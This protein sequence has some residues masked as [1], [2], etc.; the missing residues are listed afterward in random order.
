MAKRM[1]LITVT[2]KATADGDVRILRWPVDA[3]DVLLYH[4]SS[5]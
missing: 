4:D 5:S 3:L 2:K 1:R